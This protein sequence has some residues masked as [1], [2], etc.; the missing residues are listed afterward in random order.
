MTVTGSMVKQ[1]ARQTLYNCFLPSAAACTM[2]VFAFCIVTLIASLVYLFA[3]MVG[4]YVTTAILFIF[5][6]CPMILGAL[7]FSRRMLWQQQN[8]ALMVF[9]YFSSFKDYKRAITFVL[10]MTV[11]VVLI[12]LI[13]Y[14]P[15]IILFALS[16]QQL[17]DKLNVSL[18]V[19]ASNLWAL[20]S[21]LAFVSTLAFVFVVL[22]Y[23]LAPFIF[24]CNDEIESAEAINMSIIISKRTGADFFGLVFS[25]A[26]W[27]LAS[28]FLLPLI[29]TAPYFALAYSEHCRVAISEYNRDV[30][31]FNST[32][33]PTYNVE[34]L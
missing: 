21:L 18:P 32:A 5:M 22:K 12:A 19:W 16:N 24:V 20:N 26:G 10:S 31:T 33:T 3:G 17:Y 4:Y 11:R 29:F 27:I 1:V 28:L 34:E 23:Y 2:V 8:S 15:S 25:F 14:I 6:L 13:L 30:D 7:D 9:K